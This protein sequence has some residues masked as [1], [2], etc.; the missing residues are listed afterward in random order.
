[1]HFS[2]GCAGCPCLLSLGMCGSLTVLYMWVTA[3]QLDDVLSGDKD[4][5]SCMSLNSLDL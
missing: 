5:H 2:Q 4:A 3:P 1:M